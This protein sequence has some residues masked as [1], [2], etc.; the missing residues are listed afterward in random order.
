MTRYQ[1][2]LWLDYWQAAR[3]VQRS[4]NTVK[5]WRRQGMPMVL[6]DG[7]RMVRED[8]LLTWWRDRLDAWPVHRYRMRRLLATQESHES[9]RPHVDL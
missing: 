2:P 4:V 7:R 8:V 9:P 5:R 1:E 6:R 3:R